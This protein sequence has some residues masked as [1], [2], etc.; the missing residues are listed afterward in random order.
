MPGRNEKEKRKQLLDD[1]RQKAAEQFESSLPMD[2]NR[3]KMLFDYLDTELSEKN[4]D[5]TNRLTKAFLNQIDVQNID[6][7][8][9]G[10]E[11][12]RHH[13]LLAELSLSAHNACQDCRR[14][15]RPA[16]FAPAYS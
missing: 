10:G 5:D 7:I 2:R 12:A 8:S 9:T 14:E 15:P 1:L 3:F 4:C 16:S 13:K 11:M 6:E